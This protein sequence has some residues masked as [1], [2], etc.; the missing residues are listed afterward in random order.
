MQNRLRILCTIMILHINLVSAQ[1]A[2]YVCDVQHL[3]SCYE[4]VRE[5]RNCETIEAYFE[6]FPTTFEEYRRVFGYEESLN[7][8]I[9]GDLYYESLNYVAEFFSLDIDINQFEFSNKIIQICINGQWQADGVNYLSVNIINIVTT[10]EQ[11]CY[12][13][14][15]DISKC[16]SDTLREVFLSTMILYTDDEILS[17]WLFYLDGVKTLSVDDRLY[18]QTRKSIQKYTVLV[19]QLDNAYSIFVNQ[20]TQ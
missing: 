12:Y 16:Y 6:A 17:F 15:L 7:S 5:N 3:I 8:D 10:F 20:A 14:Y 2:M 9:Y 18:H 1:N 19:K 13:N 4:Q 11:N